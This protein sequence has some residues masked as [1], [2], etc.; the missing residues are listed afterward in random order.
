MLNVPQW[1]QALLAYYAKGGEAYNNAEA[2]GASVKKAALDNQGQAASEVW[3]L[4]GIRQLTA[5]ESGSNQYLYVDLVDQNGQP[6]RGAAP[7]IAWTWEGR[8]VNEPA[9]P[10][11]PDK[12]VAEA[13]ANIALG[14]GQKITV[15]I[16]EGST[17]S[18]SAANLQSAARTP[19]GS[20]A[21]PRSFYVLF[22]KQSVTPDKPTPPTT[23]IEIFKKYRISFVFDEEKLAIEDVQITKL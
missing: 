12:P 5:V 3:R 11:R 13:A 22:Q 14:A 4:V 10:V 2:A 15:W 16:Q 23:G 21:G 1:R 18:D 19:S 17:P 7:L 9:P 8:R 6:V 20:D